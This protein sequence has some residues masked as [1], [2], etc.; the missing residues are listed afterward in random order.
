VREL[1]IR[2]LILLNTMMMMNE[3]KS[4]LNQE[5]RINAGF[6]HNEPQALPSGFSREYLHLCD[7]TVTPLQSIT[8]KAQD[9]DASL[10]QGETSLTTIAAPDLG[11]AVNGARAANPRRIQR[12]QC[13]AV[14]VLGW[15]FLVATCIL[16]FL[17]VFMMPTCSQ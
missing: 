2:L 10:L 16:Y 14:D 17:I 11:G 3:K 8:F 5:E 7:S 12:A 15:C 4:N 1:V 9:T 6:L 13:T